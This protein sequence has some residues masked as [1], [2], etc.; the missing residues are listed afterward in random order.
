MEST[1]RE[2]VEALLPP[3]AAREPDFAHSFA[4]RWRRR[5][6]PGGGGYLQAVAHT[7]SIRLDDLQHIAR[8]KGEIEQNTL[9]DE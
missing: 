7:A 3:A 9:P 8:Q 1:H 5:S 2:R 6:G 4:F